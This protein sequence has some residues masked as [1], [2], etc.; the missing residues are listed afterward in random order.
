VTAIMTFTQGPNSPFF[1]FVT[2]ILIGATFRWGFRE[3]AGTGVF[4][5]LLFIVQSV[6][7]ANANPALGQFEWNRFI[8]HITYLSLA[9]LLLG[10]LA[11]EQKKSERGND[12][13]CRDDGEGKS[14]ARAA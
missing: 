8:L 6:V 9:G 11:D 2:F 10:Y 14:R 12:G 4:L 13:E 5:I 1:V 3:T 7:F